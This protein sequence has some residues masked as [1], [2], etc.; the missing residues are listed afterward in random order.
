MVDLDDLARISEL[1]S[2]DVLGAVERF[3]DQCRE[4]WTIGMAAEGLPDATGVDSIVVLGM[5][6]SGV[7]GDVIEAI[8]EPRLAVPFRVIKS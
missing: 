6:G 8:V 5:G 3:A 2:E 1:D 7:S 4:A